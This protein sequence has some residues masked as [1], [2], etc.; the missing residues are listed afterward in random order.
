MVSVSPDVTIYCDR[1][2][3][4][5]RIAFPID[6]RVAAP[7]ILELGRLAR[8]HLSSCE[9]D[10]GGQVFSLNLEGSRNS[11]DGRRLFDL[12]WKAQ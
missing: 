11:A 3:E 2:D 10:S 6:I 1:V 9:V 12:S 7:P 8:S 4:L 5:K